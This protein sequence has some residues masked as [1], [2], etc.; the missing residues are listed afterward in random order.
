MKHNYKEEYKKISDGKMK[1]VTPMTMGEMPR[2]RDKMY[3]SFHLPIKDIPQA[4]NWKIGGKYKLELEVVQ[5]AMH[6]D[7]TREEVSFEIKRV[8]AI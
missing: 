6:F 1:S 4:K 7:E 8:K 3:P 2:M 5:T